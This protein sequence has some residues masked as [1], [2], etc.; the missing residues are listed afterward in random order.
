[1]TI[2]ILVPVLKRPQNARPL[3][4]SI[5]MTSSEPHQVLFL[6][7]PGDNEEMLACIETGADVDIVGWE[8]GPGDW[9]KKINHGFTVTSSDFCLLAADDLRFHPDWDVEALRVAEETG[10]GVIGT[11]DLGN[12]TVMRGLHSTHPLVRRSYVEEQGT[13]DEPG[14]C[15]HEGYAHQ[16]VDNELIRTAQMRG[17]WAFAKKSHV[18]HLHPLWKKGKMDA[19]YEKA[20]STP[21]EDHALFM[22]RQHLWSRAAM[23]AR[24]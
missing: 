19:T 8:S 10:A 3:I 14:K 12:A 1:M 22:Q 23:R 24:A 5:A 18:E 13:I 21:K 15:L 17:Q 6:C 4:E 16:W 2:S 7:S 9:A 11:N 20:L